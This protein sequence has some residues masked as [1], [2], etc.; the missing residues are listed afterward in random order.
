[1]TIEPPSFLP[2]ED[3]AWVRISTPFSPE[4][5]RTFCRDLERL[6]RINPML[7]FAQWQQF[8]PNHYAFKAKN[9]SNGQDIDTEMSVNETEQGLKITYTSGLKT[10]TLIFFENKNDI[11][12]TELVIIDDYSGLPEAERTQRLAEVDRS[13]EAW[14]QE[15]YRYLHNWQR[16]A[17]FPPYR[18]YMGLWQSMKPM[19]RRIAYILIIITLFELMAFFMLVGFWVMGNAE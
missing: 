4:T 14:G 5:L 7:E 19:G 16:W 12:A 10:A 15:L 8:G 2:S 13:L 6:F 9:L 11:K 17:W 1:M 3:A 18:W